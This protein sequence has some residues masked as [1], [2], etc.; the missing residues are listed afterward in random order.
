MSV[1]CTS[2]QLTISTRA[3]S[4]RYTRILSLGM[5]GV[6]VNVFCHVLSAKLPLFCAQEFFGAY[7]S[8]PQPKPSERFSRRKRH[9]TKHR[10][11]TTQVSDAYFSGPDNASYTCRLRWFQRACT[12]YRLTI[13]IPRCCW[14]KPKAL[15]ARGCSS[16]PAESR[17]SLAC[18]LA[19]PKGRETTGFAA[20]AERVATQMEYRH[21]RNHAL[22]KPCLVRSLATRTTWPG[23]KSRCKR[24]KNDFFPS[25]LEGGAQGV[26]RVLEAE[27]KFQ[28]FRCCRRC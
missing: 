24:I 7:C 23:S 19:V 20:A 8:I 28:V 1:C 5:H 17:V 14:P 4:R 10:C 6:I 16:A 15:I 26:G 13:S 22:L 3:A 9:S 27:N 25:K 21:M 11:V 2:R 18:S 12:A